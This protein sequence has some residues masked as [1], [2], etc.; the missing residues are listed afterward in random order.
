[1]IPQPVTGN[2]N[3]NKESI[4]WGAIIFH[5]IMNNNFWNKSMKLIM[6]NYLK[7]WKNQYSIERIY[8]GLNL[9]NK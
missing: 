2:N 4:Q 6:Q 9:A 8:D 3:L 1:M 7:T 5:L